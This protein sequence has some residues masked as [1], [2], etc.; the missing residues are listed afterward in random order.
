MIRAIAPDDEAAAL[1]AFAATFELDEDAELLRPGAWT[2]RYFANPAGT[3]ATIAALPDGRLLAQYAGLPQ[4][5]WLDGERATFTQGVDSLAVP[6]EGRGG[7]GSLFVRVG[8]RFAQAYGGRRGEGDP[9]MWGYPV[10]EAWRIGRAALG[11]E[12]IRSQLALVARVD[13]LAVHVRD[14]ALVE[15]LAAFPD[16]LDAWFDEHRKRYAA[17]CDRTRAALEWRYAGRGYR[18]AVATRGGALRG[19][20]VCRD[21][22]IEGA[23]RFV[24]CEWLVEHDARGALLAWAREAAREAGVETLYA[25]LPP[26]C[27]DFLA[28]QVA[29]FRVHPTSRVLVGRSY[30]KRWAPEWYAENWFMTLGDTDLV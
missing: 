22:E 23:R 21:V 9:F 25:W 13:A 3:R 24:L 28:L 17:I 15:E 11:Y 6:D 26:W 8:R 5:A 7:L 10:R 20:A 1:R 30:D 16:S 18:F 2:R 27:E 19:L 29:G 12:T 14:E 4:G